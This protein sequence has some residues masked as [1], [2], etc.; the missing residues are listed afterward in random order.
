MFKRILSLS[1]FLCSFA[2]AYSFEVPKLRG[3]INDYADVI[4]A[5]DSQRIQTLVERYEKQ[6][7]AQIFVLTVPDMDGAPAI[8]DYSIAVA[9]KW[10]AGQKGKDNGV[11]LIAALKERKVRI[12]VGYGLE[13]TLTDA[14]SSRII[15]GLIIPEFKEGNYG[16][17]IYKGVKGVLA[18]LSKDESLN[19]KETLYSKAKK[20]SDIMF[21]VAIFGFI[22]INIILR[23]LVGRGGG[24]SSSIRGGFGG[25]G[26][27]GGG[28]F[29]GGGGGGFGGGGSSGSW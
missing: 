26:G 19:E 18:V 11:I 20:R 17:G 13:G 15:R 10:K 24:G 23:I 2:A 4:D 3:M 29:S 14:D 9:E 22:L 21:V 27:F 5:Q 1:L 6:T 16:T 25:F 12:E 28:G 7:G 8:E